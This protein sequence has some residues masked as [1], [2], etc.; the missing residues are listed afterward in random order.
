MADTL[1]EPLDLHTARVYTLVKE[2]L[3]VVVGKNL[4]VLLVQ[5]AT[6]VQAPV[7]VSCKFNISVI[8]MKLTLSYHRWPRSRLLPST[9][10]SI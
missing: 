3:M 9:R 6:A 7:I 5:K 1:H 4:D 8:L 10:Q 2:V